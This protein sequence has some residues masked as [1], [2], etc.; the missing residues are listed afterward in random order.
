MALHNIDSDLVHLFLMGNSN[1]YTGAQ[2]I[3]M[4][5]LHLEQEPEFKDQFLSAIR[6][7]CYRER[8]SDGTVWFYLKVEFDPVRQRMARN[9]KTIKV[10][11]TP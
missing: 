10:P 5:T 1:R 4:Y 8:D 9:S 7:L 11:P 6:R 3:Q 2:L